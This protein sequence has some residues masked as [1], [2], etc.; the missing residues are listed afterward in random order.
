MYVFDRELSSKLL[1][2]ALMFFSF[3]LLL[4]WKHEQKMFAKKILPNRTKNVAKGTK[5]VRSEKLPQI[6]QKVAS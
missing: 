4:A 2:E 1:K 6:E 3:L 5:N